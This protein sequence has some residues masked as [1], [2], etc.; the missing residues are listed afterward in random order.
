MDQVDKF[1]AKGERQR[2]KI[3]SLIQEDP[4]SCRLNSSI[5]E[6]KNYPKDRL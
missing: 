4:S 2:Q 1:T 6:M 5:I 3:L